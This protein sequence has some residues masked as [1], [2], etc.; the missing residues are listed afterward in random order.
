MAHFAA[1][2]GALLIVI[3][4]WDTF[5]T[6][7]LPRS[8]TRALR[9]TRLFYI[10]FWRV[11]IGL[12]SRLFPP[13]RRSGF[14]NAFGPLSLLLLLTFWATCLITGFALIQWGL[15]TAVMEQ[16]ITRHPDMGTQL[17]MSGSTFFTLGYGDVTPIT[18]L[19]RAISVTEAGVGLGCLA[20]VIGYLPVIYQSFSRR[21]AGISLL[22]ARAGSPPTA[23][24]LLRRHAHAESMATMVDLLRTMETWSADLLE[25]H[26][27]YPVLAYYRSQHDRESWLAALTA[28]LDV[29]ALISQRF[30]GAPE[31]E[32][33]LVWQA[34]LTFAMARHTIVD[35][36]LVFN[37]EPAPAN[38][39]RLTDV[40]WARIQRLLR[41]AG[42]PLA[43]S[44]RESLAT[45]RAQYEPYVL[46]MAKRLVQELPPFADEHSSPDNWEATA[47]DNRHI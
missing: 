37:V 2:V 19:S 25:S 36:A 43:T 22:D 40:Q 46:A 35:L 34:H 31:W 10:T 4:L 6:V 9:L 47:W 42:I 28:I 20:V 13:H 8:V 32:C 29:C 16:A 38:H 11:Y 27:S 41:T 21:E 3:V 26:L 30:E 17:Y 1:V 39:D 24:E 44:S 14:L 45:I 12:I 18:P 5:E 23:V 15:G 7:V 33:P